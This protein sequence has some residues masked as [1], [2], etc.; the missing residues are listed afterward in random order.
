MAINLENQ[1]L[2]EAFLGEKVGDAV[3]LFN[4]IQPFALYTKTPSVTTNRHILWVMPN[5]CY[6]TNTMDVSS[7]SSTLSNGQS[8]FRLS[9]YICGDKSLNLFS[10]PINIVAT[11]FSTLPF[12]LTLTHSLVEDGSD[13]EVKVFAWNANGEPAANV[14]FNWRCRVEYSVYIE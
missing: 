8:V 13:V 10:Y 4:F 9:D 2:V 1:K 14:Y 5:S 12:F 11:P 3:Q 7:F 6:E